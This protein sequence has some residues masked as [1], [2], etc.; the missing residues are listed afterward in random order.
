MMALVPPPAALVYKRLT[1]FAL[2]YFAVQYVLESCHQRDHSVDPQNKLHSNPIH[3]LAA[4]PMQLSPETHQQR[5]TRYMSYD[6][7][8]KAILILFFPRIL[9]K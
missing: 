1:F 7:T 4:T 5:N 9:Y 8:S 6:E 3:I 2:L